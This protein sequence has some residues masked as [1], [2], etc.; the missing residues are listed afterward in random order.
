M[1]EEEPVPTLDPP[2]SLRAAVL[3]CGGIGN[4]HAAAL[5][6]LPGV[7]LVAV[8]DTDAGRASETA[9]KY[10]GRAVPDM[11]SLLGLKPD[12]VTI[13]TPDNFHA[14]PAIRALEAGCDVFCEK[15]L[16]TKLEDARRM[17]AT[18]A[19]TGHRL[20]V[21]Y[22]RRF[23]F[24]YQILREWLDRGKIGVP[25]H[26][27]V[28]VTDGIPSAYPPAPWAICT[29]LLTHHIDL[30]RW[31]VGEIEDV[32]LRAGPKQADDRHHQVILTFGLVGG[33]IATL[34]AGLHPGQRRTRETFEL[35]GSQGTAF[36]DDV[37]AEARWWGKDPDRMEIARP[38][39]F[40]ASGNSFPDTIENHVAA[41]VNAM[42]NRAPAP[43]PAEAG[44]R[45]LEVVDAALR[46]FASGNT[47]R[48]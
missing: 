48:V 22:N 45:G 14:G 12:F 47:V 46:S 2:K 7:E 18:A 10:G 21:D 19:R 23:G 38:D 35:S 15:P 31:L 25:H 8:S 3:G 11:D 1:I 26:C 41:F 39:S 16:A 6:R 34:S 44:I 36:V 33:G 30:I 5:S 20:G 29:T 43:V 17:G 32:H 28:R 24:G 42:R 13:A 9:R 37:V 40:H 27:V 4:R